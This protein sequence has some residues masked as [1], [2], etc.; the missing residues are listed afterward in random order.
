MLSAYEEL[1]SD[2]DSREPPLLSGADD[3]TDRA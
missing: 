1:D 2:I 3:A